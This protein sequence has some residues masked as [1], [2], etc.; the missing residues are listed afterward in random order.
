MSWGDVQDLN[1]LVQAEI[2]KAQIFLQVSK[3][4]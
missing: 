1:D 2:E 3:G 4:A